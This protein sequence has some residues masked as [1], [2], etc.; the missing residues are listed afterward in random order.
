MKNFIKKITIISISH[1]LENLKE[2]NK[3]YKIEGEYVLEYKSDKL[4]N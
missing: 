4:S 2:S 1:N 3:L